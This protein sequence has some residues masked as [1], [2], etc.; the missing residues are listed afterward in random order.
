[1]ASSTSTSI[2]AGLP[3]K[4]PDAKSA[5]MCGVSTEQRQRVRA[6]WMSQHDIVYDDTD[7][8]IARAF[9]QAQQQYRRAVARA[10][11]ST[12][13]ADAERNRRDAEREASRASKQVRPSSLARMQRRAASEAQTLQ[14]KTYNKQYQRRMYTPRKLQMYSGPIGRKRAPPGCEVVT[15]C[16][17]ELMEA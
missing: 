9:A 5:G 11:G 17:S 3:P 10:K 15:M 13:R 16:D 4:P 7:A 8:G 14:Q 2:A 1:M 6:E 12:A